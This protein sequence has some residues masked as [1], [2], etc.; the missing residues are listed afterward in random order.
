MAVQTLV[1]SALDNYFNRGNDCYRQLVDAT[2]LVDYHALGH[3]DW[4]LVAVLFGDRAPTV[5]KDG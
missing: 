5:T 3:F 1:V 4:S 2:Y